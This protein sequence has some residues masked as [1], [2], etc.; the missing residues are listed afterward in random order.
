MKLRDFVG[1]EKISANFVG[2]PNQ[3][4]WDAELSDEDVRLLSDDAYLTR[5]QDEHREL[6]AFMTARYGSSIYP[7]EKLAQR[8]KIPML[9]VYGFYGLRGNKRQGTY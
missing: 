6:S 5:I 4:E 3:P 1:A 2:V 7:P 9:H 8:A